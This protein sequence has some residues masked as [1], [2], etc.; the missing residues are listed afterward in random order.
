MLSLLLSGLLA[1]SDYKLEKKSDAS[2]PDEE[3]TQPDR[4][5]DEQPPEDT[6]PPEDTEPPDDPPDP[7]EDTAPPVDTED[8]P[9]FDDC[10]DGYYADYFNLP[11]DHPEMELD[12]AG[13]YPGDL[14]GNHD[15]WDEPYFVR[16]ELDSNLEFG[17]DWWPVNEGLPGDPQY[18]AV[19]WFA[20][21][22]IPA[23]EVVYFELGS[24]DDSWAYIDGEM[25]ADLGGIH[26][27][28]TTVFAY[29]MEAGV[30]TLDLYMA[31]RHT[32]GAGFWFKWA[33]ENLDFYA[34]E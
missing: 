30:H 2:P 7:P 17:S 16:R 4:P 22:Y 6:S 8:V 11:A 12:I 27:V 34:C 18:F 23:D 25:V 33:S 21:L 26:G 14:P 9:D 13:L 5:Q 28:E 3:V 1:C 29:A 19:H 31:E 10:E 20:H 15:W 24:D 32:S